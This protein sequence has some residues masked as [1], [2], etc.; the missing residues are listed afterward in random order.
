MGIGLA[1]SSNIVMS[2]GGQLSV[3]PNRDKPGSTFCF[4]LPS[5]RV[6]QALK[7]P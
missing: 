1:V 7:H 5:T 6:D 3:Y 4:V 2:H